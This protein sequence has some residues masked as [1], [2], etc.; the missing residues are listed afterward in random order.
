MNVRRM[1]MVI[2]VRREKIS[3]CKDLHAH[4]W[5]EMNAALRSANIRN[6]SIYLREPEN[7]LFDCWQHPGTDFPGD[8]KRLGDF[9]TTKKWLALTGPCQA[10][11][12]SAGPDEWR[13]AM[14][15]V[16]RLD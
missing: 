6:Y 2:A 13:A 9:A 3:L 1:G 8:M 15:E 11:L 14:E 12:D 4:P 7:L 5:P 16:Y 10:K